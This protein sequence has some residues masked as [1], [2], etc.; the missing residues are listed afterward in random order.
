[1]AKFLKK[2]WV[3]AFVCLTFGFA[4]WAC[5]FPHANSSSAS[6]NGAS[7]NVSIF[8]RKP[9]FSI[10][11]N[12]KL[13]FVD[14]DD[15]TV[16]LKVCDISSQA[17]E[18]Q[19]SYAD[20]GNVKVLDVC[21][22]GNKLFLLV[23]Q[24][25]NVFI[26]KVNLETLSVS[27][28]CP[29]LQIDSN[30][31]EFDV[32][33][34]T[35]S[36]NNYTLLTFSSSSAKVKSQFA[37]VASDDSLTI[38]PT[39]LNFT[40]SSISNNLKKTFI[41][42]SSSNCYLFFIYGTSVAYYKID[43]LASLTNLSSQENAIDNL[44]SFELPN[45]NLSI[46]EIIVRAGFAKIDNVDYLAI[47][48]QKTEENVI[49]SYIRLYSFDLSSN[50]NPISFVVER[51]CQN[52]GYARMSQN[53][54]SFSSVTEQAL[55]FVE[56]SNNADPDSPVSIST[57]SNKI[58]NPKVTVSYLEPD[59][60]VYLQTNKQTQL[61]D[62]AW[63]ASSDIVLGQATDVIKIGSGFLKGNQEIEDY[64]Y[65]LFTNSNGNNFGFIKRADLTPKT[66]VSLEQENF[67][68]IVDEAL[69]IRYARA[70]VW[71]GAA[72]Y[73]LPTTSASARI[74]SSD[75]GISE[76]VAEKIMQIPDNSE[77]FVLDTLCNYTSN[78]VK[79]YKVQIN[80]DQFGFIEARAIRRPS[81]VVDFIITNA[82]IKNDNTKVFL[83]PNSNSQTFSFALN[84]GKN[85]R[86]NGNRDTKTGFTSI[87]FND[88]FGNEFSGY[89]ETDFIKADSWSTLQIVGSVL[90]AINIGLLILILIFKKNH[91]GTHGQK[92]SDDEIISK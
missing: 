28:F 37:L 38:Q 35:L 69:N 25:T 6:A 59:N 30:Y 17:L 12:N 48:F 43:N 41:Y 72:L 65:C 73:S 44:P 92:I 36:S 76:L 14:N 89:I 62:N 51:D 33:S 9:S 80:S 27:L 86:I 18:L 47:Y 20:I 23:S 53:Y 46:N 54:L 16:R 82:T 3:F 11:H 70:S 31:S 29:D 74:G 81:D 58:V 24:E 64:D 49:N 61:F 45:D 21:L 13:F 87:T 83:E 26:K 4:C 90:I 7:A 15:D 1:M 2:I 85:V 91:L 75:V 40:N 88:E 32:S 55:C 77:V 60:F 8:I 56:F 42:N 67:N 10:I 63:G 22:C 79:F 66:E 68:V 71:P 50:Q 39:N 78:G 34:L 84:K 19:N 52:I 57:E 5:V